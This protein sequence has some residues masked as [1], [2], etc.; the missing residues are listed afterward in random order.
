L[1]EKGRELLEKSKM[2]ESFL[3]DAILMANQIS[4]REESSKSKSA[5]E[6][7][8]GSSPWKVEHEFGE[9][10]ELTV[11][12]EQGVFLGYAGQDGKIFKILRLRDQKVIATRE[13]KFEKKAI[14]KIGHLMDK[15]EPE[16]QNLDA[17]NTEVVGDEGED[18]ANGA[19]GASATVGVRRSERVHKPLERYSLIVGRSGRKRALIF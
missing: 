11:D 7:F 17:D 4:N 2:P 10:I 15:M 5:W 19:E 14:E 8:D 3:G 12:G 6:K 18:G 16:L 13:V 1:L 9:N